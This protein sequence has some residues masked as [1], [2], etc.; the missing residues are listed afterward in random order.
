MKQ[1]GGYL[2]KVPI[3]VNSHSAHFATTTHLRKDIRYNLSA[4]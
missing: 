3:G 1:S 4:R 2:F